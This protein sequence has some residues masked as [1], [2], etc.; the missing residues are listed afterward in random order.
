MSS[1]TYHT[2]L[3]HVK[4]MWHIL[5]CELVRH[6]LIFYVISCRAKKKTCRF[7]KNDDK[8]VK[9]MNQNG[10]LPDFTISPKV[11]EIRIKR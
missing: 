8:Q 10:E 1:H 6:I 7:T 3:T 5:L 9:M 4:H 11:F 2:C